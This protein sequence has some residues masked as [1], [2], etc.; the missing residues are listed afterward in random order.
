MESSSSG[1]RKH[2]W[3]GISF[4]TISCGCWVERVIFCSSPECYDHLSTL[5]PSDDVIGN[6]KHT[7]GLAIHWANKCLE[8]IVW[9]QSLIISIWC[10]GLF[11]GAEA[12]RIKFMIFPSAVSLGS[13][14]HTIW[15]AWEN[16]ESHRK[17]TGTEKTWSGQRIL[18]KTYTCI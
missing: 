2:G 14:R 11:D 13:V 4:R 9:K 1:R 8:C 6:C 15:R 10:S 16:T 18:T 7:Y 5:Y 3:G 12:H 17:N